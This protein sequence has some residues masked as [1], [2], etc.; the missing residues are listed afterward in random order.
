MATVIAAAFSPSNPDGEWDLGN[1]MK[2][3]VGK[4]K[5]IQGLRPG[6]I[7][8]PLGFGH[9]AYGSNDFVVDGQVIHHDERR[10]KGVHA[11]AAMR[12]DPVLRNTPLSDPVGASV[13]FY[14][15]MMKVV[16]EA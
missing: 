3:L 16:K 2:R 6:T 1:G 10:G 11:N 14:D 8:F 9:W 13:A 5:I 12:V 15:S 7:T 4:V